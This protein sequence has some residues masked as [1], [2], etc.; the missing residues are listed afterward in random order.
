VPTHI[1]YITLYTGVDYR[2]VCERERER[3]DL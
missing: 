2:V 1:V 3:L